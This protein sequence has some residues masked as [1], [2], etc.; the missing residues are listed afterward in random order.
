MT[1]ANKGHFW[2]L[3][4]YFDI[5]QANEYLEPDHCFNNHIRSKAVTVFGEC[6]SEMHP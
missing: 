5:L 2:F 6:L 4:G 1:L 3:A